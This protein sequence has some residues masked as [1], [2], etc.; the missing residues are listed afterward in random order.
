MS[1]DS[2]FTDFIRRIRAGDEQVAVE[3][4]R[5]YEPAIRR[6]VR[7]RLRDTR[8]RRLF[9]SM[10]VCQSVLGS[11]FVRAASGGYDL[12]QPEQ[13]LKLLV[14]MTRNKLANQ[15]RQQHRQR[16]DQRRLTAC[17]SESLETADD[18]ASPSEQVAGRELL[19]EFRQRLSAEERQLADLRS[20]G[21]AWSEVAARLGGTQHGRRMQLNRAIERVSRELGLDEAGDE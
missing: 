19:H 7:F 17:S 10:D 3:L 8:L 16:R 4:V 13:L 20:E 15:A 1:E 5:R 14:A 6:E 9:D 2:S 11:F 12:D 21:F 18:A